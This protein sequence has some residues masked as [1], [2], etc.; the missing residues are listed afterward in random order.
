ML[1]TA[2]Q[3]KT[4]KITEL[5]GS[6]AEILSMESKSFV[7]DFCFEDSGKLLFAG[8]QNSKIHI[9]NLGKRRMVSAFGSHSEP[10]RLLTK[11]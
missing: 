11:D 1:V 6:M 5:R 4:I 3:D 7:N 10:V 8:C 2:G 9:W